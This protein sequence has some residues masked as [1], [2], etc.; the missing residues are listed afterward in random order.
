MRILHIIQRYW[1]IHGGAEIH[2]GEISAR[3]AADGHHLTV[4]TSDAQDFEL[5][6]DPTSERFNKQEVWHDDVRVLRFPVRHL[7]ISALTYPGLRRLLWILSAIRPVPLPLLLRIARFTPWIPDL[8]RW[9]RNTE[10]EFDLVAGMTICF[11]PLLEAGLL[12]ARRQRIPFVMYPLT[13]LGAG[14]QPGEDALSRFYTMRHQ[15][16]LAR[17]SDAIVAQTP[18]ERN[19]YVNRGVNS[20]QICVVG[21]GFDPENILGGNGA[22]FRRRHDLSGPI[23][24]MLTKMSFDKG[25]THT[26][27][28]MQ[29]LWEHG[30]E[31]HLVLAGDIL[32]TFRSY[33]DRLPASVRARILLLG[34]I[35]EEEKR[36]LLAAGDLL[37]MPS[38]TDSF[39]IV[40]LEAW[41]YGKPV[42][43]A[44]TWGVMDVIDD[45]ED[46]L[47][48]PFGDIAAL[49]EAIARLVNNPSEACA[50]GERGRTKALTEHTWDRKYP[51]VRDLY[52][53]L[54]ADNL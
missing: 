7:P 50:M 47:L 36:D 29:R 17:Q 32:D 31:G 48:V 9:L 6:W 14:S 23:V 20:E 39:G 2:L 24:F 28:A 37:V 30:F 1:P 40:Y 42:I 5:F 27:D 8:W 38:R 22:N 16:S 10:E 45:Q 21:P 52:L 18:A 41:A 46:G 43:G 49:A 15:V 53:E 33:Y 3:L 11:E 51:Y 4:A 13:H 25:V 54:A 12:Y 26:V 19:F 34:T 44:R 35:S